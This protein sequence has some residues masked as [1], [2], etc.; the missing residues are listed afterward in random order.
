[1]HRL[2]TRLLEAG[3]PH[4]AYEADLEAR[5]LLQTGSLSAAGRKS[6]RY[7]TRALTRKAIQLEW[8]G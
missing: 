6:L 4:L 2:S 5:R 1:M 3:E 8:D 7:G